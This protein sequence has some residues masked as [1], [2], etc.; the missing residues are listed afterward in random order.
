[1]YLSSGNVH[2]STFSLQMHIEVIIKMHRD[3]I[4]TRHVNLLSYFFP[5]NCNISL[6]FH[7]TF[8]NNSYIDRFHPD[9]PVHNVHMS[10]PGSVK[11]K[12]RIIVCRY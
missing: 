12:K 3:A 6:R 1:M 5:L 4:P 8:P 10:D 11:N 9:S 7:Y 2:T